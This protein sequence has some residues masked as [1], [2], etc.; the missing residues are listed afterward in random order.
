MAT[1]SNARDPMH[2]EPYAAAFITK[3]IMEANGLV[4]GYSYWT[5]S[6]IFEENYF[7]SVP[8]HGGFG[9]LNIHGIVKPAY[10][11]FEL[12]HALGTE[13]LMV[14]GTHP[15]VDAWVVR[16]V[17]SATVLLTNYALPRHP[18]ATETM[19][20]RLANAQSP[21]H[22]TIR[23]IDSDH[24]NAKRRW[25]EIGSSE[26]LDAGAIAEL[27]AVSRCEPEPY[28]FDFLD[29]AIGCHVTLPP[30]AVAAVTWWFAE[31]DRG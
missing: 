12:L 18:I 20:I 1:S 21:I 26:Y 22:A 10:R 31:L 30:L 11:A 9:L 28:S 15:T 3:T 6:D 5:F 24:A 19:Q 4:H 7:P 16:G 29:N 14:E 27:N 2:D 17:R 25:Q 8:F 23:R 13:M